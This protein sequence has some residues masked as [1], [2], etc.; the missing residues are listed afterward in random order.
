MKQEELH[1]KILVD[2]GV[3]KASSISTEKH[4]DQ[5]NSKVI[6]NQDRI[7][8]NRKD[9]EQILN[10]FSTV[11]E[12]L[13]ETKEQNEKKNVILTD[14]TKRMVKMETKMIIY[15]GVFSTVFGVVTALAKD[16]LFQ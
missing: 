12:K 4:L 5:L 11:L 14:L 1:T 9:I 16:L 10:H 8:S 13:G 7:D 15:V 6:K 2:L 3:I